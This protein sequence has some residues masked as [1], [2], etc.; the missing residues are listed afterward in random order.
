MSCLVPRWRNCSQ[1][2][3]PNG[4][5]FWTD[6]TKLPTVRFDCREGIRSHHDSIYQQGE[7]YGES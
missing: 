4:W 5:P 1:Q 3:I 6:L 7:N 2:W